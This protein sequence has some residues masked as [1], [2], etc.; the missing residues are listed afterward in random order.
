MPVAISSSCWRP[1]EQPSSL[2]AGT[3]VSRRYPSHT[4]MRGE[5]STANPHPNLCMMFFSPLTP[6]LPLFS[7]P[8]FHSPLP[9]LLEKKSKQQQT[10]RMVC[11]CFWISWVVAVLLSPSSLGGGCILCGVRWMMQYSQAARCPD[12]HQYTP[13]VSIKVF[14]LT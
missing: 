4:Q 3:P 12:V 10:S 2:L 14:P 9:C 13:V 1:E 11:C 5:E 6:P 8:L 7:P